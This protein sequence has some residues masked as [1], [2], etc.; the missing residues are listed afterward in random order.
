MRFAFVFA[1]TKQH[2]C[3][4]G[5]CAGGQG[6]SSQGIDSIVATP[7]AQRIGWHQT[8]NVNF[9]NFAFAQAARLIGFKGTHQPSHAVDS[10]QTKV[11]G[12]LRHF[13][14]IGDMCSNYRLLQ[15]GTNRFRQHCH[16]ACVIAVQNHEA[17]CT[18]YFL[19]G[20][21]VSGHV[22]VPI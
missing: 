13:S 21:G 15:F 19:F 18:K 2:G 6:Q 3:Q 1:Q 7:N 17:V 5:T 11:T 10:F 22:A 4:A 9:L 20:C 14:T 12:A 8:L 16:H